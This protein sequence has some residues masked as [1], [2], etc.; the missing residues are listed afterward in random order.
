MNRL[1]RILRRPLNALYWLV[2][3][4]LCISILAGLFSPRHSA[5]LA[6]MAD[7]S[8]PRINPLEAARAGFTCDEVQRAVASPTESVLPSQAVNISIEDI[9]L[10][11]RNARNRNRPCLCYFHSSLMEPLFSAEDHSRVFQTNPGALAA[12]ALSKALD[13]WQ[14]RPPFD[15]YACRVNKLGP[16]TPATLRRL[17]KLGVCDNTYSALTSVSLLRTAPNMLRG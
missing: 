8:A 1:V 14:D 6:R 12:L 13:P 15:L 2:M 11:L 5:I 16:M 9:P 10:M 3:A 17:H 4:F 7:P